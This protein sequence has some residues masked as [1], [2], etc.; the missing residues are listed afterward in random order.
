MGGRDHATV[1][2]GVAKISAALET[3]AK[4]AASYQSLI[5]V[6]A[7]LEAA[8][9]KSTRLRQC[10]NDVDPFDVAERILA[11]PFRDVLPSM[12]EIRALCFGVTHYAAECDRL[13]GEQDTLDQP[14]AK[15]ALT[16]L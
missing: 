13:A 12:E 2:H 9:E 8:S 14:A 6:I 10:F 11:A 3:D 1:M 4:V 5:D 15:P 7:S 16:D